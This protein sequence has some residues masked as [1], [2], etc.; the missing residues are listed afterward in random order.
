MASFVRDVPGGIEI[1]VKV[2]PGASRSEVA[3]LLG[4]RLKVR[5]AAPPED[6]RANARLLELLGREFGVAGGEIIRG[7]T[8]RE[9]TIRFEGLSAEAVRQWLERRLAASRAG[10]RDAL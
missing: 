1:D 2:V 5:V 7:Q 8:N 4:F 9:K 6:G 10:R 3:G